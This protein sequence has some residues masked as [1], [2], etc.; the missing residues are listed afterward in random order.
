[1]DSFAPIYIAERIALRFLGFFKHW[2]VHGFILHRQAASRA[3]EAIDRSVAFRVTLRH[4]GE[5]LYQ[6]R[7]IVGYILGFFFRSAR[8]F[9]GLLAYLFLY[10]LFAAAYIVW[11]GIPILLLFRMFGPYLPSYSL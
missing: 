10:S 7:S 1:M 6:D 9:L 11:A 5:P 4:F 3:I 2:Y 8:I